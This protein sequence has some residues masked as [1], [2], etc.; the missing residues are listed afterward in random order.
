MSCNKL[1]CSRDVCALDR[2]KK[3]I[4][5]GIWNQLLVYY[6]SKNI[7]HSQTICH[8]CLKKIRINQMPSTCV[9]NDLYVSAIPPEISQLNEY[10]KILIQR[11]KAFQA[12]ISMKP[13]GK[14]LVPNRQMIKK[15]KGRTFH[16]PLPLE[17]TLKT[18][19]DPEDPINKNPELYILVRGVPTKSKIIW[20]DIVN[21]NKIYAALKYLKH[22][23]AHYLEIKLP[24]I[25]CHLFNSI[26]ESVQHIVQLKE[27][28]DNIN[29]KE[30][31]VLQQ[32]S[33]EKAT[34]YE[35]FTIYPLHE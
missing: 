8:T 31:P 24:G 13:I 29:S 17:E 19:P 12:L 25:P 27:L 23:N 7:V 32:I 34:D 16:L 15:V 4:A 35:Q 22:T 21:V 3:S 6:N 10:E 26:S 30:S 9:L 11:A 2:L 20:E 14:K 5:S 28:D 33:A 18:L 1:F